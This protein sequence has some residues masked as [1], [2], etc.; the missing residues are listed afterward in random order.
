MKKINKVLSLGSSCGPF[1]GLKN[2]MP[3][4]RYPFDGSITHHDALNSMLKSRFINILYPDQ[5]VEMDNIIRISFYYPYEGFVFS[6]QNKKEISLIQDRLQR[7]CKRFLSLK[8]YNDKILF[9]R[10]RFFF[11]S[12]MVEAL[13]QMEVL[14]KI[15]DEYY[16]IYNNLKDFGFKDFEFLYIVNTPLN[17]LDGFL[18]PEEG[19]YN[20]ILFINKTED[21]INRDKWRQIENTIKENFD[22]SELNKV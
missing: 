10:E 18:T 1:I 21:G 6:H 17:T 14:D 13:N 12:S 19:L 9:I 15:Q 8:F 2:F 22:L 5:N 20:N 7:R 3:N 4:E 11:G 16:E